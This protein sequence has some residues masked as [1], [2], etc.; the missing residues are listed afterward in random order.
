MQVTIRPL[1][2]EHVPCVRDGTSACLAHGWCLTIRQEVDGSISVPGA[3][4]GGTDLVGQAARTYLW[5]KFE[6][7]F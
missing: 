4:P 6:P 2:A 1:G 3:G 5:G 7:A